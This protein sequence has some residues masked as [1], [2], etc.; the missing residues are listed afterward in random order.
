MMMFVFFLIMFM[1]CRKRW[2][3]LN[4]VLRVGFCFEGSE[5]SSL[6]V[7]WGL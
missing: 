6:F 1:W 2:W 5:M 7:V 3:E 4:L